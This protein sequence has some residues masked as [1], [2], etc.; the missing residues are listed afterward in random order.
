VNSAANRIQGLVARGTPEKEPDDLSFFNSAT[1]R[2]ILLTGL[3]GHCYSTD[4]HIGPMVPNA[5]VESIPFAHKY[6]WGP[7]CVGAPGSAAR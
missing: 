7:N 5:E 2:Q 4:I 6:N 1:Q 3:Y